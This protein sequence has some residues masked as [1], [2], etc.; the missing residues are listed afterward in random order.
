MSGWERQRAQRCALHQA[1]DAEDRR[2][3]GVLER[4][5]DVAA[6]FSAWSTLVLARLDDA[7][8]D[9]PEAVVPAYAD[10]AERRAGLARVVARSRRSVLADAWQRHVAL[11]SAAAGRD[12]APEVGAIVDRALIGPPRRGAVR[13][14]LLA[15]PGRRPVPEAPVLR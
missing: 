10:V 11:V 4:D 3:D 12:V 14:V 9:G 13:R 5:V 1:L 7:L 6:A 2:R 15:V 8:D